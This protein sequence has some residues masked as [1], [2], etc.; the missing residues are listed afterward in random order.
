ML[1]RKDKQPIVVQQLMDIM[2]KRLVILHI[3]HGQRT[4]HH[5]E[6]LLNDGNLLHWH[7]EIHD[8]RMTVLR[9]RNRQHFFGNIDAYD[10]CSSTMNIMHAMFSKATA[11]IKDCFAFKRWHE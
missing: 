6:F 8:F 7:M 11:K 10:F 1:L 4:G 5:I 3:L 2:Q 9:L